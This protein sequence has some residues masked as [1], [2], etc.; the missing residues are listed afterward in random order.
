MASVY[1]KDKFPLLLAEER[2]TAPVLVSLLQLTEA[3]HQGAYC[4][5]SIQVNGQVSE[6]FHFM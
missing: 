1:L 4:S 2:V 6:V 3:V 5:I